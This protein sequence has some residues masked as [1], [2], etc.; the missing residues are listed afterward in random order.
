MCER[1]DMAT[2]Q[3]GHQREHNENDWYDTCVCSFYVKWGGWFRFVLHYSTLKVHWTLVCTC[4][5][6]PVPNGMFPGPVGLLLFKSIW[7]SHQTVQ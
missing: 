3:R 2:V 1:Y 7:R 4:Y 6:R 5:E